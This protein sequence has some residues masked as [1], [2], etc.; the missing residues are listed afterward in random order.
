MLR[1]F[2]KKNSSMQVYEEEHSNMQE[3]VCTK[4]RGLALN[5]GGILKER[6]M[7]WFTKNRNL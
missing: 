3:D 4:F 7:L 2:L 1:G 5:A 6:H